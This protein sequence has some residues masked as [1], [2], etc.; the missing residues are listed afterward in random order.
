MPIRQILDRLVIGGVLVVS[1]LAYE[2]LPVLLCGLLVGGSAIPIAIRAIRS[3]NRLAGTRSGVDLEAM[4]SQ[5]FGDLED[6]LSDM[7]YRNTQLLESV[8]ERID[9]A[10]RLLLDRG[11]PIVEHQMGLPEVTPI[12]LGHMPRA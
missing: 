4:L 1:A 11:K 6:R 12:R 10:E 5:R 9:W 8:E 3:G 2:A 7:E